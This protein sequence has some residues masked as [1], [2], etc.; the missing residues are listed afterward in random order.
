MPLVYDELRR[1]AAHYM[2]GERASH[3]LQP[4]ALV[5]EM[6]LRIAG[7]DR[8]QF[9]DRAHFMAMAATIMRRVLVDHARDR[10]R[11]KRGGGI[12]VTSLTGQ[13]AAAGE[14][15]IDLI[16]HPNILVTSARSRSR[17]SVRTHPRSRN[18]SARSTW[19]SAVRRRSSAT[20]GWIRCGASRGSATRSGAPDADT[21]KRRG[22]SATPAA[23]GCS[24]FNLRPRQQPPSLLRGTEVTHGDGGPERGRRS[25]A[26]TEVP[27]GD[28]GYFLLGSSAGFRSFTTNGPGP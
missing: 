19:G 9:R 27:S 6:Y 16:N 15:G 21:R 8:L 18:S 10:A 13:D 23:S 5:N 11:D 2:R 7:L 1:L 20:R 12:S 17:G 14:R 28:G 22:R 26:G 24:G 25:R 3:T 4:T